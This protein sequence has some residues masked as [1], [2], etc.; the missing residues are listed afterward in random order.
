MFD[1]LKD[2][3]SKVKEMFGGEDTVDGMWTDFGR[4][5][6]VQYFVDKCNATENPKLAAEQTISIWEQRVIGNTLKEIEKLNEST[7]LLGD[8]FSALL[9]SKEEM[10][11]KTKTAMK[12]VSDTLYMLPLK[13]KTDEQS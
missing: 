10:L 1:D 6:M 4:M 12:S 3:E 2:V 8:M 13:D 5:M 9:P 7:G 11:E